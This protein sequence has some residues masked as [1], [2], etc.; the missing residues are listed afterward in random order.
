M[1]EEWKLEA[2]IKAF[3]SRPM[4]LRIAM[5]EALEAA[6]KANPPPE[7]QIVVTEGMMHTGQW[8]YP[9][10]GLTC[11]EVATI[12]RAMRR[13][14]PKPEDTVSVSRPKFKRVIDGVP[15]WYCGDERKGERP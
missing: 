11:D 4:G 5:R 15:F 2:A 13:L 8:A 6:E 7:P 12:Y 10:K 14:E 1:I 9:G 3:G